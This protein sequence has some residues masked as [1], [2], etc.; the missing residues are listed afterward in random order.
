MRIQEILHKYKQAFW[1]FFFMFP[2][3]FIGNYVSKEIDKYKDYIKNRH[4]ITQIQEDQVYVDRASKIVDY[5]YRQNK[6]VR[7]SVVKKTLE[8]ID[9]YLPHYFPDGPFTNKD[10]IAMAMV[11]SSFEQYL[12]GTSGEKGIFQIMEDMSNSMG[13]K[14]NQ[15]DIETNTEL[16]MYVLSEKYKQF[17]D[18]RKAI[19]AYN[20][21]IITKVTD[22]NGKAYEK[23]ND[24]YWKAFSKAKTDLDIMLKASLPVEEKIVLVRK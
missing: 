20:G 19:I 23:W 3:I 11:E 12:V 8:A 5:Y 1:A 2:F 15:F 6:A 4:V 22:K 9:Y 21:V 24:K 18:Y 17:P 13:V 14:K 7:F 16:G 10:F